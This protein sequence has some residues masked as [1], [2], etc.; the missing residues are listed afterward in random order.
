MR[1][2]YIVSGILLILPIIDF[3]VAAPALVQ[4]K[5]QVGV[6]AVHI[7]EAA[8]TMLEKR[9]DEL[10]ELWFNYL[11]HFENY[12]AKPEE[13]S[14]ARPP[15]SSPPSGPKDGWTDVSQPLPSI[16]EEPSGPNDGWTDVSQPLPSIP[17][18]PSPRLSPEPASRGHANTKEADF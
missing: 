7:P 16:P 4:E 9:G 6:D 15:P 11:S 13:S 5:R 1:R 18:E 12:F 8:I 14:V 17:E 10:N 2:Y 3:A